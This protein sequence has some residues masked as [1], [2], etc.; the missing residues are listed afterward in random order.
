[1]RALSLVLTSTL[2]ASCAGD[3]ADTAAS[4]E[5]FLPPDEPGAWLP[6]TEAFSYTHTSGEEIPLQ[7]WYPALEAD[8]DLY[9]YDGFLTYGA[10]DNGAPDC[11]SPRPVVMFSHGNSGLRYQSMFLTEWLA[12]RGYVVVAPDHVGNT[13]FDIDYA[14]LD[15]ITLR[16]PQDIVQAFDWLARVSAE[17]GHLLEG[18]VDPGAGYAVTG[19][20][21]GGYTTMAVAAGGLDLAEVD[22]WCA[23]SGGWLCGAADVWRAEHPGSDYA[24]VGDAERVWAAIPM[25]PAGYEVLVGGLGGVA[26]PTMVLG[27]GRD[28]ITPMDEAVRPIY[29]DL[30]ASPR[31]LGELIDADHYTFSDACYLAP[32]YPGCEDAVID[33]DFAHQTINTAT[34][35]LLD[36]ARGFEEASGWLPLEDPAWRWTAD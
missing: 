8:D 10:L 11:A 28:D 2:G 16:R 29:G 19:H 30:T 36:A 15:E 7:V 6:G 34:T 25:A 26:A 1:M 12:A 9:E 5:S 18:C 27:G 23:Q 31:Y 21:F 17:P 13:I 32:V 33:L 4:A 3:P 35:A 22:A 24:D 14:I 20:S